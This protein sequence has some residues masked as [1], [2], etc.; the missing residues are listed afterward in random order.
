MTDVISPPRDRTRRKPNNQVEAAAA[1]TALVKQMAEEASTAFDV[2]T[3]K[4]R[5]LRL[6][7]ETADGADAVG[8]TKTKRS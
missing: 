3:A 6:A 8:K 2:K 7:K 4:L 5:A 1:R